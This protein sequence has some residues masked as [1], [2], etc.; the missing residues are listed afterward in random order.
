MNTTEFVVVLRLETLFLFTIIAASKY[1]RMRVIAWE[2]LELKS[3][4]LAIFSR[5]PQLLLPTY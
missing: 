2:R 5:S 1:L 3:E 4:L